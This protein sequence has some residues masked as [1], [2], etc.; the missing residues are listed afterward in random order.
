MLRGPSLLTIYPG[1]TAAQIGNEYV[2][3]SVFDR[4]VPV[5]LIIVIVVAIAEIGKQVW[6]LTKKETLVFVRK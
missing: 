5:I 1:S 6:Q 2:L 4:L 3:T